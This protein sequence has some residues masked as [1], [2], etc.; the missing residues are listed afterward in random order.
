MTRAQAIHSETLT[1]WQLWQN[2][3]SSSGAANGR[4]SSADMQLIVAPA[5]RLPEP[6]AEDSPAGMLAEPAH[7]AAADPDIS[8]LAVMTEQGQQDKATGNHD[9]VWGL[10]AA[11]GQWT[12]PLG[13]A[14]GC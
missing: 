3:G 12:M 6:A 14:A 11:I 9:S 4:V 5:C 10:S 7:L 1:R 13:M 8:Q 2:A